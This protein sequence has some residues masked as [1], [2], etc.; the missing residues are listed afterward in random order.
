MCLASKLSPPPLTEHTQQ[1]TLKP[2]ISIVSNKLAFCAWE[3]VINSLRFCTKR[4]KAIYFKIILLFKQC[5]CVFLHGVRN[6]ISD[7]VFVLFVL[8][9]VV[10]I[11]CC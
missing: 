10:G 1:V 6:L 4:Q 3:A 7:T 5:M 8:R 9:T 11:G 2:S